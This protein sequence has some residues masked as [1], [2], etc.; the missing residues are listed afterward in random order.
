[1][2][3]LSIN[4]K[5][6]GYT[7]F[8]KPKSKKLKDFNKTDMAKFLEMDLPTLSRWISGQ[9]PISKIN[10]IRIA[11]KLSDYYKMEITPEL[12]S[13]HSLET[14]LETHHPKQYVFLDVEK[15]IVADKRSIIDEINFFLN[16][17]RE[18]QPI[19]YELLLKY[20]KK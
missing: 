20:D 16:K 19:I 10:L 3:Y 6:I 14:Y 1:M 4:L 13:N 2:Y 18:L 7:L 11:T 12:L 8:P 15:S 9:N 5:Y 17:H